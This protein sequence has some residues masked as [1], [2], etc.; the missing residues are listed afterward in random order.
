MNSAQDVAS[1]DAAAALNGSA[2]G[3][4]SFCRTVD[5][6][7]PRCSKKCIPSGRV[8]DGPRS[9]RSCGQDT[10]VGSSRLRARHIRSAT[11]IEARWGGREC[12]S[13][14]LSPQHLIHP[15]GCGRGAPST[16][17]LGLRSKKRGGDEAEAG[18]ARH[19]A[20]RR[21]VGNC[22]WCARTKKG[23]VYVLT[24]PRERGNKT[25]REAMGATLAR[26]T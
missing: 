19:A 10:H 11:A 4:A 1:D 6:S 8:E 9:T 5:G 20:T 15:R 21:R 2:S 3:G 14:E 13:T 22:E 17:N 16:V 24:P 7:V 18:N 12:S 25:F 23:G 26:H